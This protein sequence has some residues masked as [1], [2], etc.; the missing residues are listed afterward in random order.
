MSNLELEDLPDELILKV[1]SNL[2]LL[3][4][5]RCGQVSKRIRLI[6]HDESI[7]QK[8]N[9]YQRTVPNIVLELILNNGCKYLSLKETSIGLPGGEDLKIYKKP[10]LK[11]LVWDM[12]CDG[13]SFMKKILTSCYSLQKL[14]LILDHETNNYE[15]IKSVSTQNGQTLQELNLSYF[16]GVDLPYS[17]H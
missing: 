8:V 11:Y 16:C 10:E 4:L 2:K 17:R 7:W 1:M 3:D 15:T 5:I 12:C 14:S 9:L 6:C 13:K